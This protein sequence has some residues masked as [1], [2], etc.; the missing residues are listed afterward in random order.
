M[1]RHFFCLTFEITWKGLSS[2]IIG[3][4]FINLQISDLA[5]VIH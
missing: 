3:K 4:Y 5:F 1:G 2:C